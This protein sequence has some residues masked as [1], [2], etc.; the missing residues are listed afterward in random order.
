MIGMPATESVAI[1]VVAKVMTWMPAAETTEV[2]QLQAK[3]MMRLPVT[4]TTP[5]NGL[6]QS[7]GAPPSISEGQRLACDDRSRRQ[8]DQCARA[9]GGESE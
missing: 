1:I 3:A 8:D 9:R 2:N 7:F 5:V 4:E 6:E